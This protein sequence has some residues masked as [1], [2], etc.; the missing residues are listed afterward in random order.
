VTDD[1]IGEAPWPFLGG[2]VKRVFVDV[3]GELFAWR[4]KP[5]PSSPAS[6]RSRPPTNPPTTLLQT[7]ACARRAVHGGKDRVA[8]ASL[9]T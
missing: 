3:S 5:P 6:D 4:E 1:Y 2:T 8:A 7:D 9:V